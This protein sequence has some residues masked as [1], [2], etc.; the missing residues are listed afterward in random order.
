MFPI[1]TPFLFQFII[2]IMIRNNNVVSDAKECLMANFKSK[3]ACLNMNSI[4][5]GPVKNVFRLTKLCAKIY[6]EFIKNL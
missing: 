6:K 1:C 4:L 3:R 5:I 2:I